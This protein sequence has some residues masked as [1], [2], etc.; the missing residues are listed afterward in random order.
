MLKINFYPESDLKD[1]AEAVTIFEKM[2]QEEG[3]RITDTWERVTGLKFIETEINAVVAD[4]KSCSHPL[5]LRYSNEYDFKKS[6]LVHEL[7]HRIL[8]RRESSAGNKTTFERHK[9]LFL[10]LYDVFCE[11]YGQEFT[12][13]VIAWDSSLG[14]DKG[15]SMYEDAW[16]W[17]LQYKTKEER[18]KIYKEIL[19]GEYVF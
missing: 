12:Y 5:T 17:A 18:Q 11:L 13:K 9:F 4:L 2:W 14:K 7:G 6:T 3:E 8:Y 15:R 10:V 16:Q 19:S 1:F